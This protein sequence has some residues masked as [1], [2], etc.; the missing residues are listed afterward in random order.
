LV[1]LDGSG[2]YLTMSEEELIAAARNTYGG[3]ISAKTT[4]RADLIASLVNAAGGSVS[5]STHSEAEMMAAMANALGDSVSALSGSFNSNLAAVVNAAAEGGEGPEPLADIN[6]ETGSYTVGVT[7]Y[8]VTNLLEENETFFTVF[9]TA[10][11][12]DGLG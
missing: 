4:S 5:A 9:D 10:D 11:I 6:F 1:E 2:S 3:S 7:S 12:V 8:A